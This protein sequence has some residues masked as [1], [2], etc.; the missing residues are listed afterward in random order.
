MR[1]TLEKYH[2]T[3][4]KHT[5]P[6][7]GRKKCFVYYVDTENG[8]EILDSSCG[9]CDHVQSCGYHLTPHEYFRSVDL[10]VRSVELNKKSTINTQNYTINTQNSTINKIFFERTKQRNHY[11]KDFLL[12]FFDKNEVENALV[13]YNVTGAKDGGT[14]FWQV[15]KDLKIRTGKIIHY[16]KETGHRMKDINPPVNWVHSLLIRNNLINKDFCLSQCLFG[17]NLLNNVEL[18]VRNDELN[19]NSKVSNQNS[20][21]VVVV[22]VESEK[23]AVVMSIADKYS[24]ED[25]VKKIWLATG[26]IQNLTPKMFAVFKNLGIKK[27]YLMPDKGCYFL[28]RDKAKIIEKEL[29]INIISLLTVERISALKDGEDIADLV[30][31]MI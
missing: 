16:N 4:S 11:F 17:E 18:L 6:K 25:K 1:Y 26:G 30:F 9:K 19:Q 15:D 14:I 2:G 23:T 29:D 12:R 13:K 28:W 20:K 5:C 31:K 3:N 8:N 10:G 27:V 21:A 22:V 24:K 7:C